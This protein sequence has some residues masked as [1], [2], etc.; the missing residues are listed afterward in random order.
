[1]AREKM[2]KEMV[3][4]DRFFLRRGAGRTVGIGE[5]CVENPRKTLEEITCHYVKS[6]KNR[7]EKLARDS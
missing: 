3:L 1:M 4:P 5:N 2:H 6:D 7:R